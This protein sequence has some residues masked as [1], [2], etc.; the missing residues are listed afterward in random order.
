MGQDELYMQPSHLFVP[1][2]VTSKELTSSPRLIILLLFS[3]LPQ[4]CL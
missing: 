2:V 4:S 3:D 1:I